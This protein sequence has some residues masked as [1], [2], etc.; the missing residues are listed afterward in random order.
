MCPRLVLLKDTLSIPL[1]L[2]ELGVVVCRPFLCDPIEPAV[3]L[4]RLQLL[5]AGH[6]GNLA[7][8]LWPPAMVVSISERDWLV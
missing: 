2:V 6:P 1:E 3:P 5:I 8:L 4:L 7:F